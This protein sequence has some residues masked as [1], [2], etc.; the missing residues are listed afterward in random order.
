MR[1]LI[2][3]IST[4][5]II[6]LVVASVFFLAWFFCSWIEITAQNL[7]IDEPTILSAWNLFSVFDL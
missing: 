7:N 1:T 5:L 2:S 4:S 3:T 6:A